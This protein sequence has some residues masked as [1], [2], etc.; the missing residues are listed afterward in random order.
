MNLDSRPR[1]CMSRGVFRG[2]HR[3]VLSPQGAVLMG[4]GSHH[5]A[6]PS[7]RHLGSICC[8]DDGWHIQHGESISSI[9][10]SKQCFKPARQSCT[11]SMLLESQD[12]PVWILWILLVLWDTHLRKKNLTTGFYWTW[13]LHHL[14]RIWGITQ[15]NWILY[16]IQVTWCFKSYICAQAI[17]HWRTV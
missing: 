5:N 4:W 13:F 3:C 11:Y 6:L 8:R 7:L 12:Q 15:T 14:C 16:R 1:C 10:S 17:W 9:E 2:V